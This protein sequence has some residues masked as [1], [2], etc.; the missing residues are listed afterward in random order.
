MAEHEVETINM[1]L[2]PVT[3]ED[4]EKLAIGLPTGY[5]DRN[6]NQIR[7]GDEVIYYH[8]CCKYVGEEI[9]DYPKCYIVGTGEKCYVYSGKVVRSRHTV[10]FSF[11]D[12]FDIVKDRYKY[13]FDCDEDGNL[14]TILVDNEG[15]NPKL[16]LD[17]L[18]GIETEVKH[19]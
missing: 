9:T 19:D 2:K 4:L 13:L 11:E 18:L 14:L 16:S 7:I 6:G 8:K 12:G 3:G 17:E 10:T 15:L 1:V 5:K